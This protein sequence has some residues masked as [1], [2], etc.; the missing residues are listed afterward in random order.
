M[1]II[2]EDNSERIHKC[3]SCRSIYAYTAKDV[4]HLVYDSTKCP[5]CNAW[6]CVSIFDKRLIAK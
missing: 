5:V 4:D 6:N 1:R 2:K 3:I